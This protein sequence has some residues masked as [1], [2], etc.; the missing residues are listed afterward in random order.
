MQRSGGSA[1]TAVPSGDARYDLKH[2]DTSIDGRP[3]RV[4]GIPHLSCYSP[5]GREEFTEGLCE[6][7]PAAA[8]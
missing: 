5:N 7:R 3:T 8:L 4:L 6:V 2:F 1:E